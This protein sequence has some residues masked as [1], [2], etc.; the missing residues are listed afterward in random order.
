MNESQLADELVAI[1]SDLIAIPSHYPP[2]ESKAICAYA[3]D[4]LKRAGL[5]VEHHA[6][7]PDIDNVVARIGTGSPSLVFNAHV[8]TVDLGERANW[9]TDPFTAQIEDGH[10]VG[11][12]AG[13]C[14]GSMAVHLWLAEQLAKRGGPSE[15]EVVFTFVGDEE[16]LGLDGLY[17]LRETGVVR[18][19]MLV[20]GAQTENQL[21]TE[22]RGVL[23]LTVSTTGKAAHAGNPAAGDNAI[24][25]MSR[26][27]QRLE[28]DLAPQLAARTA[29]DKQSTMNLGLIRGG[30]N[31]N[32]VPAA[33]T[34][35]IDRRLLPNEDVDCAFAEMK[36]LIEQIDEPVGT[37]D[38]AFVTGT[39]G[40]SAPAD[41][42]CVSAFSAAIERRLGSPAQFLNATGVSDGRYFANDGIE[43]LNFGPG[44]GS[45]GHAANESVPIQQLVDAALIQLDAVNRLTKMNG[46]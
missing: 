38:V 13:N 4:R 29:D 3:G 10:V 35:E 46:D 22:E 40:F 23:W 2:G 21:I 36:T 42:R 25:R 31:A 16:R 26:I 39:N 15:G 44:A 27:I 32:V 14:K 41:G 43:I 12:G 19:D 24:T 28:T 9:R 37:V 1:L 33:C 45:E 20:L 17:L 18:P 11:L 34:L 6:R 8:D 30:H 5:Q 7:T